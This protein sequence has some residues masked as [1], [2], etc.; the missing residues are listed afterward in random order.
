MNDSRGNPFSFDYALIYITQRLRVLPIR[1]LIQTLG[2][3]AHVLYWKKTDEANQILITKYPSSASF[4]DSLPP[5]RSSGGSRNYLFTFYAIRLLSNLLVFKFDERRVILEPQEI[6]VRNGLHIPQSDTDV[7]SSIIPLF[8]LANQLIVHIENDLS[9]NDPTYLDD[10]P[11]YYSRIREG[12][13]ALIARGL[14]L[15]DTDYF[16]EKLQEL[17]GM[18]V[19]NLIEHLFLLYLRAVDKYEPIKPEQTFRRII[20]ENQKLSLVKILEELSVEPQSIN[21]QYSEIASR[22]PNIYVKDET[23]RGKVFFKTEGVYIC[24][25]P[26]LMTSTFSDF[27]YHYVLNAQSEDDKRE[28][29]K[30][31]GDA[32]DQYIAKISQRGLGNK[33]VKYEYKKKPHK[34]NP[35]SDRHLEIDENTRVIIEIKGVAGKD[36]ARMGNKQALCD[37]FIHLQGGANKPK[38]VLQVIKDALKFRKDFPFSGDIF[39][40]II[41]SGRFPET[42][43][44]DELVKHEIE[45]DQQYKEY[46]EEERNFPTI[47]L[48]ASTAELLFCAAIQKA[49]LKELLKNIAYASPSE[50]RGKIVEFLSKHNKRVSLAPL[51]VNELKLLS[52]KCKEMEILPKVVSQPVSAP[53]KANFK[54]PFS[55][56]LRL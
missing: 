37:K 44:F 33:S 15:Y 31:Y 22:L 20:D 39:T 47:W 9:F 17:L 21:A 45:D 5:L 16:N 54:L 1:D 23:Y 10:P 36:D 48:S 56:L 26:D 32:F 7:R 53:S 30:K 28:F 52:V 29:F 4:H 41:F 42:V 13:R 34:G 8:L 18:T 14:L 55:P 46:L 2:E 3:I 11:I 12:P 19:R 38:G 40:V 49:N 24:C 25:R 51:F 43:D 35:S 6:L 27:P 50:V